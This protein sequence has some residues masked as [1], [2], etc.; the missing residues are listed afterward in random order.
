MFCRNSP[1]I[2]TKK[3]NGLLKGEYASVR[4]LV[5]II[6]NGVHIK[7]QVNFSKYLKISV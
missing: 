3:L 7:N 4:K 2:S 6:P 1:K 5:Q